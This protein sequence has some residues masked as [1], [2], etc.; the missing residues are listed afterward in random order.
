MVYERNIKMRGVDKC[1]C[2]TLAHLF[3]RTVSSISHI[4][5]AALGLPPCS[6]ENLR[7]SDGFHF[8]SES[9]ISFVNDLCSVMLSSGMLPLCI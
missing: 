3:S 1:G 6:D 8:I 5:F 9:I 4:V 7:Q 2:A